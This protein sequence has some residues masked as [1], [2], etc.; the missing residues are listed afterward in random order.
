[1]NTKIFYFLSIILFVFTAN[2]FGQDISKES[3]NF[4]VGDYINRVS[5]N[6]ALTKIE[7]EQLYKLK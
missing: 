6:I 4:N 7:K 3:V 5:S 2:T 1:M